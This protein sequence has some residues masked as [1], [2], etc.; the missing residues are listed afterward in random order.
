[1]NAQVSAAQLAEL[2]RLQDAEAER[3]ED[4]KKRDAEAAEAEKAGFFRSIWDMFTDNIG[5]ML[6]LLVV[7]IGVYALAKSDAG[8]DFIKQNFEPDTQ[9]KINGFL[10]KITGMLGGMGLG[11]MAGDPIDLGKSLL[12]M[13][14]EKAR[15]TLDG[16]VPAE[17]LPIITR[18][19]E[20]LTALI[21]TAKRANGGK[22]SESDDFTNDKTIFALMTTKETIPLVRDLADAATKSKGG[23]NSEIAQKITEAFKVIVADAPRVATLL[24]GDNRP[25]TVALLSQFSKIKEKDINGLIDTGLQNGQPIPEFSTLLNSLLTRNDKGELPDVRTQK[26]AMDVYSKVSPATADA[27]AAIYEAM[28]SAVTVGGGSTSKDPATSAQPSVASTSGATD[29]SAIDS[30]KANNGGK[31]YAALIEQLGS[32]RKVVFL[33]LA[34]DV[35]LSKKE[36]DTKKTPEAQQKYKKDTVA[37]MRFA[38]V[39]R[40]AFDAFRAAADLESLHEDIRGPLKE[41]AKLPGKA[42]GAAIAIIDKGID[43]RDLAS[44]MPPENMAKA[45]VANYMVKQLM[46]EEN[47]A[48]ITQA[49][50]DHLATIIQASA[51]D[52]Q[53]VALLTQNNLDV[54]LK[55]TNAIASNPKM[56]DRT[57]KET[58][59]ELTTALV[60]VLANDNR[61]PIGTINPEDFAT[62]FK[63]RDN[64]DALKYLLDN[65]KGLS[66]ERTAMVKALNKHWTMVQKVSSDKDGAKFMI[67]RL[68][69]TPDAFDEASCTPKPT[70]N[71]GGMDSLTRFAKDKVADA[72]LL[73]HGARSDNVIGKNAPELKALYNEMER[74][75]CPPATIRTANA[76]PARP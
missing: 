49:G 20:T 7:A 18:N 64:A 43:L 57:T 53:A 35:A 9:L 55:V 66:P 58:T 37:L 19:K 28:G 70:T 13:P 61:G 71:V 11:G 69:K 15:Q 47:R 52:K 38:L 76:S 33:S 56:N 39:N 26:A 46:K 25:N 5:S 22:V 54:I 60:E 59:T 45:D 14:I 1:M 51:K 2:K 68:S 30:I 75:Q 72:Y 4:K 36:L 17:V 65:M 41:L 29:V 63:D 24:N 34:G 10:N 3:R 32:D 16:H 27:V 23:A 67:G 40:P 74:A 73:Y 21:T 8:Q 62:F 48:L 6:M 44:L 12:D 31:A 50:T 42:T